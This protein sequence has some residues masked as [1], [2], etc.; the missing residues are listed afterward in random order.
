[1]TSCE[2]AGTGCDTGKVAYLSEY[3]ARNAVVL[4]TFVHPEC[5]DIDAYLCPQCDSWHIGHQHRDRG[6]ACKAAALPRPPNTF[7]SSS[8]KPRSRSRGAA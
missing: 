3:L 2:A 5:R 7:T 8:K 6:E 4:H 1:M